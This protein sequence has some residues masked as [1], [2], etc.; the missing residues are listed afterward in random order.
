MKAGVS[1]E[2]LHITA[3]VSGRL[4]DQRMK[5]AGLFYVAYYLNAIAIVPLF[6]TML[7]I[8]LAAVHNG[9]YLPLSSKFQFEDILHTLR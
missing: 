7:G 5:L 3:F 6:K 4:S 9:T 8:S 2:P 1:S